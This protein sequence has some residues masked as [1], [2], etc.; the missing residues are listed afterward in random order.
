MNHTWN[1][2]TTEKITPAMVIKGKIE[3]RIERVKCIYNCEFRCKKKEKKSRTMCQSIANRKKRKRNEKKKEKKKRCEHTIPY[4]LNV[5]DGDDGLRQEGI[6][7]FY[8][9]GPYS[10]FRERPFFYIY[11]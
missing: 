8:Y 1:T 4:L 7:V 5:A 11:F 3:R 10:Q 2:A 9:F 6:F